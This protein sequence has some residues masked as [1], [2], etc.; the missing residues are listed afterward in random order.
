MRKGAV[1]KAVPQ[2]LKCPSLHPQQPFYPGIPGDRLALSLWEELGPLVPRSCARGPLGGRKQ[3]IVMLASRISCSSPGAGRGFV[4]ML[5]G[6][7]R[8][9]WPG[10]GSGPAGGR[11][12]AL[13][14][15]KGTLGRG[16]M[17]EVGALCSLGLGTSRALPTGLQALG[18][19]RPP[20]SSAGGAVALTV[21]GSPDPSWPSARLLFASSRHDI[22]DLGDLRTC[23]PPHQKGPLDPPAPRTCEACHSWPQT[24]FG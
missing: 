14:K 7:P 20:A 17:P 12:G 19:A 21:A 22:W 5:P 4:E 24:A 3:C 23:P 9:A 10:S 8:A 15:A 11:R 2:R 16:P 18:E 13:L 1:R 6:E